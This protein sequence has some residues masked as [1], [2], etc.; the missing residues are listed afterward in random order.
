MSRLSVA[1]SLERQQAMA[2]ITRPNQEDSNHCVGRS[3]SPLCWTI[4]LR[5]DICYSE[6][7]DES[8]LLPCAADKRDQRM[9]LLP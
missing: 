6:V 7:A 9:I 8:S 2:A 4:E 1:C 3:N 5:R